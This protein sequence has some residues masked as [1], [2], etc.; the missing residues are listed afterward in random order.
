MAQRWHRKQSERRTALVTQVYINREK[1]S[2]RERERER[3][4]ENR[5]KCARI[6][7]EG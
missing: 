6:G 1:G 3:E 7:R 5:R 2:E 4:R